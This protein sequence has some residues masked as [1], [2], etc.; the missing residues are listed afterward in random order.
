M[1][2]T[3]HTFAER[4]DRAHEADRL[5]TAVWPEHMMHDPVANELFGNLFQGELLA[6]QQMLC[7]EEDAIVGVA[8][9]V[10]LAWDPGQELPDMGWDWVLRQ[11]VLDHR[12]GRPPTTLSA[13][14]AAVVRGHQ[15]KGLSA[16]LVRGM[17]ALARRRGLR[18]L[19]APVRPNQKAQYPLIPMER[20][21][22]WEDGHGLPFDSWL[23]V[24]VRLGARIERVARSSM[25]ITGTVAEWEGWTGLRF[26]GSGSYVVPGALVPVEID[27]AR[28]VGTYVEPNVWVVHELE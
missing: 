26:P 3:L 21:V 14:S 11:A 7:D 2:F 13:I 1:P 18:R 25:T 12:A 20:Y 16:E 15:G 17:R 27:R 28:D 22:R 4:P 10:P 19:I 5:Q 24:H 8:F 9:A 6:Y 23:R